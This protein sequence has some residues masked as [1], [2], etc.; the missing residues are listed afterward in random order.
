MKEREEYLPD[1]KNAQLDV[2][3]LF[4]GH[5]LNI[6][7]Q[8]SILGKLGINYSYHQKV[9]GRL[10]LQRDS[11]NQIQLTIEWSNQDNENK[12]II[13][14]LSESGGLK[15]NSSQISSKISNNSGRLTQFVGSSLFNKKN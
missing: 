5:K 6:D 12:D 8:F 13:L 9:T 4:F 14:P 3:N 11:S 10:L 15:I 1:E 7:N 2:R